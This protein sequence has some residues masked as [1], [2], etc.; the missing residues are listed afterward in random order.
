VISSTK[1]VFHAKVA[2]RSVSGLSLSPSCPRRPPS[3]VWPELSGG[4]S[5]ADDAEDGQGRRPV[6]E[7]IEG[8]CE[9]GPIDYET[10]SS[11]ASISSETNLPGKSRIYSSFVRDCTASALAPG[12]RDPREQ[13]RDDQVNACSGADARSHS[14]TPGTQSNSD[15]SYASSLPAK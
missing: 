5:V 9:A 12:R 8:S 14:K 13:T 3:K 1:A 11:A 15:G 2:V 7:E 6:D 4:A 10:A